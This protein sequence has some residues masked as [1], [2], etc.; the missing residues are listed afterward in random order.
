MRRTIVVSG[1]TRRSS[2]SKKKEIT[3]PDH[4]RKDAETPVGEAP[5][6]RAFAWKAR[7]IRG[8]KRKEPS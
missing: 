1:R 5:V 2:I 7:E 4:T 3:K 6:E 8:E